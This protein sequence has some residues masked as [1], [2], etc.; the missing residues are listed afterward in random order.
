MFLQNSRICVFTSQ[1]RISHNESLR[2]RTERTRL[3]YVAGTTY[4]PVT[5]QQNDRFE[6]AADVSET[7]GYWSR[8]SA[9]EPESASF[10]ACISLRLNY[11]L[12]HNNDAMD[13]VPR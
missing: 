7:L 4:I 6:H 10:P 9:P 5:Q 2:L 13:Q 1:R 8:K 11:A 3:S 12:V